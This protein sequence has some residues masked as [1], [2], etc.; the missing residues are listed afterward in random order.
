MTAQTMPRKNATYRLDD[1]IIALISDK[2]QDANTSANRWLEDKL[3]ELFRLSDDLPKDFR[4]VGETRGKYDRK[5][6]TESEQD[7]ED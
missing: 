1:R 3:I 6:K 5:L 7:S 2:A 4:P